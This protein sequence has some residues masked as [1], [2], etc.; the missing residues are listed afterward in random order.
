MSRQYR[1]TICGTENGS[2]SFRFI[3]KLSLRAR[4]AIL[5]AG[6]KAKEIKERASLQ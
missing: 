5:L 6:W 1:I 3:G 2:W 4:L